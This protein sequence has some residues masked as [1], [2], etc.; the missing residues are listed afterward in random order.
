MNAVARMN[1]GPARRERAIAGEI[2]M[3]MLA[4]RLK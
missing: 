1:I 2:A 4:A 3:A